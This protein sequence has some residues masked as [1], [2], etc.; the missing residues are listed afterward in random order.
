MTQERIDFSQLKVLIIDDFPNFC[1]ALRTM[2]QS[3]GCEHIEFVLH[4]E[5]AIRAM[6][7]TR[8]DIVLCDYNLGE[9]KNGNDVLEEAKH[10][11]LLKASAL[12]MM[13]TAEN[14]AEMVRGA[15]EYQPDDYL[16]KPFTKEVLLNRLQRLLVRN[17]VF[18]PVYR[19]MDRNDMQQA[20]DRCDQILA[21]VP[22]YKRYAQRLKSQ[23]LFDTEAFEDATELL[24]QVLKEKELPWAK[25][26]L[27]KSYYFRQE[28]EKAEEAFNDLLNEDHGYVQAWDWKARCQEQRGDKEGAQKS[29]AEAVKIS[30]VNVR[31]QVHLGDL[32]SENGNSDLAQRAFRRA[33]KVGK[34]SIFRKPDSYL[35][36]A[37]ILVKQ[38]QSSEGLSKK[39]VETR[40]LEATDELRHLYRDNNEIKARSQMVDH[41][42]HSIQGHKADADKAMFRA[43]DLI[44]KDTEGKLPGDLKEKLIEQLESTGR[45]DM[46]DKVVAAMQQ[47]ESSHNTLAASYYEQ[48]DLEKALDA[49]KVAIVEK[50]RSYAVCLNTAQV[51]IHHMVKAGVT[52]ELV[53]LADGALQRASTLKE[54]DRRYKLYQN[55]TNRL[56]KIKQQ[57]NI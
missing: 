8:F 46:A 15:L 7:K 1:S 18:V 27:G 23:L 22:R 56:A 10:H 48:G 32:A 39:L 54:E 34:N 25:L 4:G 42:V 36:L 2:V 47:E 26:G 21:K 50:P 40:A 35:K 49:L 53:E 51:A 14:S 19:A 43:Y 6:S 33:I 20:R 9:G 37:A 11:H 55:L 16:T 30:P 3:F 57:G 41:E 31:R 44:S 29:L 5:D 38:L 45:Q 13:I 17:R 28:V 24:Q 12:F 52:G